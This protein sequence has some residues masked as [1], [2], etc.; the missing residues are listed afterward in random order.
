[1]SSEQVANINVSGILNDKGPLIVFILAHIRFVNKLYSFY[2]IYHVHDWYS[3]FNI[4]F[5]NLHV[6]QIILRCVF[7]SLRNFEPA[8]FYLFVL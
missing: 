8:K 6:A 4:Y 1:M 3:E 5:D 2:T 7:E